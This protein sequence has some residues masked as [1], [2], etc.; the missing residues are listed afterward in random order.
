MEVIKNTTNKGDQFEDKVY[1]FLKNKIDNNEYPI[2]PSS[3]TKVIKKPK[4]Y[5]SKR[6]KDIIFDLAI[7]LYLDMKATPISICIIECKNYNSNVPIDD[8]EEFSSK[9]NQVAE[10]NSKGVV[11]TTKGFQD[12]S[13]NFAKNTGM[14][15]WIFNDTDIQYVLHRNCNYQRTANIDNIFNVDIFG[16][17]DKNER[18]F[19]NYFYN[20]QICYADFSYFISSLFPDIRYIKPESISFKFTS[21]KKIEEMTEFILEQTNQGQNAVDLLQICEKY[22]INYEIKNK[23]SHQD[24]LG[25][26][27]FS[28]LKI[29]IFD[30][31]TNRSRFTLAHELGHF[32]LE[33]NR[34]LESEYVT[35]KNFEERA[36][37][38]ND[39]ILGIE[40]EANYF[41]STLLLPRV[42]VTV[43]FYKSIRKYRVRNPIKL[44]LDNQPENI[45]TTKLVL[46]D[47]S[48]KFHVSKQAI[49]IRLQRLGLL[50]ND[51]FPKVNFYHK[52]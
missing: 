25:Q 9:L 36:N 18:V 49:S 2:F 16:H 6:G 17:F 5:S 38:Y 27:V 48:D 41:A 11:I 40:R 29:T 4:Y 51:Q 35:K 43:A 52:I 21:Y 32:F 15:L 13:L 31:I 23:E 42:S 46:Q 45:A 26:I 30:G 19:Q 7:E 47:L 22:K 39:V 34:F 8:I 1:D 37:K 14:G 10:H 24:V 12:G 28:P 50:I 44:Y 20:N 33:H 3:H